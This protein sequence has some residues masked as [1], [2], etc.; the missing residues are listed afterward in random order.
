VVLRLRGSRVGGARLP[1]GVIVTTVTV[2]LIL[3][4]CAIPLTG[5]VA[6]SSQQAYHSSSL[7]HPTQESSTVAG[8]LD[9]ALNRHASDAALALFSDSATVSDLSNIAC[10][11]GPSPFCG[12]YNVF[13]TRVQI[14]GWLEQLVKENVAVREVGNF[15][16]TGDSV[17][18][19]L[20]VSVNEFR[21]LN[22][23]PLTAT[24]QAL[25]NNGKIDSL[26]IK[27]TQDSTT[28]LALAYASN[29][30]TPYSILAS[31]ISLGVFVLGLVFPG[32]A[33]YYISRVKRLFATVPRL[34]KPWILL[35]AGVGSLLI[36]LLVEALRALVG[37][38]AGTADFIFIAILSVCS[39]FVMSAMVLMKRAIVDESID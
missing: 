15:N 6:E 13:T 5:A 18:W 20:E 9:V 33:I 31:G 10:L 4:L 35:S 32:A 36:S 28:K 25:V 2:A 7:F 23:A 34:D 17:S 39:F 37:L 38:S 30:R 8:A 3:A 27:L 11:P 1:A 12:G 29:Q 21:R 22:V 14:R 16:V 26:T 19:A 24:A